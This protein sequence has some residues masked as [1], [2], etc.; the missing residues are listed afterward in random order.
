MTSSARRSLRVLAALLACIAA[1]A[2]AAPA[3][4][5]APTDAASQP[6]AT[7]EPADGGG[8][9][10]AGDEG[11]I[12]IGM[13]IELSGPAAVQGQAYSDA[14][15]LWAEQVNAAGGILGRDV[16]L[17]ILDNRSDQTE[18]V[19][20][21]RQLAEGGAVAMIGPGTSPTTLAAMDAILEVGIPTFSMGSS[22]AIVQPVEERANVFKAPVGAGP[23]VSAAIAYLD[24]QG[25]EDVGLIA[26]NN[27]Y[28]ESGIAGWQAAADAGEV[29]L[30]GIERFEA[31]DTDTTAQLNNL[32]G[33][34]AQA[35]AVVAIPPGAPTVR[36]NAVET[37]GLEV[38]MIFDAG[39]GAELFIDL[40]GEAAEGAL[41]THP[42]TLIWDQVPEDDPQYEALQAFGQAYTE[43]YGAMSGFAG[44]AWD[45]LGLLQAAIEEAGT[46]EPEQVVSALEGLGE[47]VGVD[48][49]YRLSPE[50][51]QGLDEE[52]LRVL[53]V[54]EGAW[55]EAG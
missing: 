12:V 21:T 30:S 37:L 41:V 19:T 22:D 47:Y 42:P 31:D 49:I 6:A 48:G 39:A 28:G 45:A 40:A 10:S 2:C 9:E 23:N 50:D 46:T 15:Q 55:V 3:E 35:I 51:H 52:S 14:G 24:E 1:A 5:A 26:V 54:R 44:Y 13:N 18:A 25:I 38:P 8:S 36:R 32:I 16:E 27:P 20:L 7:S 34:G 4:E 53:T 17:E 29:T 11:P 33:A 43:R